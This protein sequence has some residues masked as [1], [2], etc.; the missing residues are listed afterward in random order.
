[1]TRIRI[2]RTIRRMACTMAGLAGA[3]LALTVTASA[4]F[5]YDLPPSGGGGNT[6]PAA[7]PT[8]PP[9]WNKHPPLSAL[10]AGAHTAVVGGMP[11]WQIT[12]IAIAS[13]VLAAVLAVAVDRILTAR[14][15]VSARAT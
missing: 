2:I 13:A 6:T 11:G 10:H 9:G 15:R 14:R 12:L 7:R 1:M 8:L 3:L 5:A 4:A